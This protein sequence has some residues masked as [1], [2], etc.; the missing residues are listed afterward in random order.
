[1]DDRDGGRLSVGAFRAHRGDHGLRAASS[2]RALGLLLSAAQRSGLSTRK[3]ASK[4]NPARPHGGASHL[5]VFS[6]LKRSLRP[7]RAA[8]LPL[9]FLA[10]VAQGQ[11]HIT[12]PKE[13]FGHNIGD[14][15][16]LANY[17]QFQAYWNKLA[18]ESDRMKLVEI[19]KSAEG[20]S[21]LMAIISSP[22]NMKK[23][24]HYKEISRRLAMAEGL[25]DEQARSLAKDG[26]AI[27]WIDGGLHATEVLGA[28]QLMET[29]YQLL[30]RNDEETRRI[31]NDDIILAVH[32]N[33]DGMQLVSNWYMKDAD[34]L[35]RNMNIPR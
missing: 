34:S 4:V 13:Q 3:V 25:T 18:K 20:R 14:D 16:W 5:E 10:A 9:V 6:M 32:V 33:P 17:D 26:K 8:A 2:D 28:A 24:D 7:W 29:V 23:L 11:A 15:Y 21:Q 19:G 1:M 12:S 22:E 30:S 35:K 31:L 27:V